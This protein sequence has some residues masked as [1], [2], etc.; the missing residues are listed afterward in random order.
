M[1]DMKHFITTLLKNGIKIYVEQGKL[2]TSASKGAITAQIGATIKA[3]KDQIIALLQSQTRQVADALPSDTPVIGPANVTHPPLSFS[4]QRLWLLDQISPGGTQ[5]NVPVALNLDGELNL[6]ALQQALASIVERHQVLRTV[7]R[8]DE[9][10]GVYQQVLDQTLTLGAV[11]DLSALTEQQ[12]EQQV[13]A[14]LAL[15]QDSPFELSQQLMIRAQVLKLSVKQHLLLVNMHHIASD[16]WSMGILVTELSQ[17]YTAYV[18]AQANPLPSLAIQYSDYAQW[19]RTSLSPQVLRQQLDFWTKN[20]A[21]APAVH[22]LPLD[23]ARSAVADFKGGLVEQS[24]SPTLQQQLNALANATGATLFMVLNAAFACLIG[25]YSGQDDI[26]IGSPMANR[27]QPELAPLV[28]FFVNTLVLRTDLSADP[29]FQQLL[30]QGKQ[31]FVAASDHQQLPFEKLVDELNVER[32][33][34]HNPLFQLMLVLQNNQSETFSL[35]GLELSPRQLPGNIAKFDL[36]LGVTEEDGLQLSWEYASAL[37]KRQTIIDLGE[38]FAVMLQAIVDTPQSRVSELPLLSALHIQQWQQQ[39][40]QQM[41]DSRTAYPENDCIHHL[42]VAQV[43][44]T[45]QAVALELDQQTVTYTQLEQRANQLAHH[46]MALGVRPDTLVGL[47]VDRSITMMVAMLAILKAGGA[48]VPLDPHYPSERLRYIIDDAKIHWVL[49]HSDVDLTTWPEALPE[50]LVWVMADDQALADYATDAPVVADL[51]AH[52][53]AYVIYTSGSTGQPKGVLTEHHN[54]VRLMRASEKHYDFNRHDVWTLFHSCAFDFSVWEIWGALAYGGKLVI[55]PHW[56]ARSTVDFY[57]LLHQAKVTVL[58][59]TPSAFNALIAQDRQA[60]RPLPLRYVIFGGEALT[61][62]ALKPWFDKHGDQHPCLVNMYGITE[63]TVHVTYKRILVADIAGAASYIGEPLADLTLML[64]SPGQQLVPQGA[65]GEMYVAGGGLARGYLGRDALTAERFIHH[66]LL[67]NAR[68]YRTGDLARFDRCGEL[69][70]IGRADDQLKLRGF[71]IEPGE[72]VAALLSHDE[73]LEAVVTVAGE[74][75]QLTAY[76]VA[77]DS[78]NGNTDLAARL[79]VYLPQHLPDYMVPSAY[80]LLAELPLTANGKLDT[81]ALPQPDISAQMAARY[82]APETEQEQQLCHLWQTLLGLEQVG[83]SDNF[84][85]IGG[86]SI[87]AITLVTQAAEQGLDFSVKDLFLYQNIRQLATAMVGEQTQAV[88]LSDI[89]PFSL[90]PASMQ[91]TISELSDEPHVLDAFPLSQLQRGMLYHNMLNHS[92][93]IY[94]DVFSFRLNSRWQQGVFAAALTELVARHEVLRSRFKLSGEQPVQVIYAELPL[95]L[96]VID[97]SAYDDKAQQQTID[98]WVQKQSASAFD[99][100]VQPWQVVIHRLAEAQFYY[101]LSFHHAL[102]DGWSVASLNTELFDIYQALLNQQPLIRPLPPLPYKH[103]IAQEQQVLAQPALLDYWRDILDD[104]PLLWWASSQRGKTHQ[105]LFQLSVADSDALLALARQYQVQEK[106][107]LLCIHLL[108]MALISGNDDVVTSVVSNA[109]VAAPGGERTLG[110]FLNTLPLRLQGVS[111]SPWSALM[112]AAD[113]AL[114]EVMIRSSYPLA[115][116]QRLTGGDFSHS[117]FNFIDFHVYRQVADD[118]SL[119]DADI[120]EKTN[121][122]LSLDFVKDNTDGSISI[123][124]SLDGGV[125]SAEFGHR[126]CGYLGNI[127]GQMIDPAQ[128]S[129]DLPALLPQAEIQQL[130]P[131]LELALGKDQQGDCI[132]QR[133]AVRA[134]Q[135]PD[136]VAL[137]LDQQTLTYGQLDTQANQ[138]AHHLMTLGVRPDRL[139]GLCVDRSITMVV[140][141]LAILKAG[142]AYVPLDPHYPSERLHYIIDDAKVQLVVGHSAVDHQVF[143]RMMSQGLT[144]VVADDSALADYSD[145]APEVEG[146]TAD[147]LAYVIYTSG[148]TGQPKGV[149]IE[150]RNIVRLFD[151]SDEFYQFNRHDVWTLFHSCAFDFSVWEIWGAL[152]YGAKL[153]IVPYWTARSTADFYQLLIEAKVTVLNQTPSAFNALVSYDR[154]QSLELEL[155]LRYV[156]FGGEALTLSAL[157][158]W[159]DK[160][161]DARPI[162]VNMYGITETTVHVTYKRIMATDIAST[163]SYIGQPLADLGLM[164]LS[165]ALQLV[166]KGAIGEMHVA[167]GGVARGYLGRDNLTAERFIHHPLLP[168]QRLYRSGD[169]ARFDEQG[170]LEYMGRSDDQLKLRGFRIEPG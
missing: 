90:L 12:R 161:G 103:F 59:Q 97:L 27:E 30:A 114:S 37:F 41:H 162:L 159:C 140:A 10:G 34:S 123:S 76:I 7:Y 149:L 151:S 146:L 80:V 157:Q 38:Q 134:K 155:K 24:L 33:L 160:Y 42:F 133:F 67:A 61:L 63:T 1:T 21:G 106:S 60:S 148:S 87:R 77:D 142:G 31:Q 111:Q 121:Y 112:V 110:L 154:Q 124:L 18:N 40:R 130:I 170:E 51:N 68:L 29:S 100:A 39:S 116:V 94:H 147:H 9:N 167:G 141:M 78:A 165:P 16:G 163:S 22:G 28:G 127:V 75:Q 46:L 132:H 44:H 88:R 70:Y 19:Q 50:E 58:N 119:L 96:T 11:T 74:N 136:A 168:K 57:H 47:C 32:R 64:L 91:T 156:I 71:R 135:Y 3:N 117:L 6:G 53:L 169:L 143:D 118:V 36:T 15:E 99:F 62:S 66:P 52:H 144:W 2:R 138:L 49:G 98:Q 86:D 85:S 72:I 102:L 4:Q 25:R 107:V 48:Y 166:P 93:G 109:R 92:D 20:L 35:P 152:N 101:H 128:A 145:N 95:P 56:T 55:V 125:F 126:M 45:P 120:F 83:V 82:I 139:V 137:Q 43:K 84:F 129:P 23:Y 89:A 104:A 26:V 13:N 54:V 113:K 73:V 17:L 122:Q 81:K 131:E 5:Y 150:H 79:S 153:V 115:E 8:K 14:Y 65:I 108:L 164:L 158:P 69:E 105:T